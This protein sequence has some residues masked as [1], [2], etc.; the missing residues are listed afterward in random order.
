M[1]A[2]ETVGKIG[3]GCGLPPFKRWLVF[4]LVGGMGIV[5]QLAV[6]VALTG[7]MDWNYLVATAAAV[8]A[9]VLHNFFWHEHWTWAE[10]AGGGRVSLLG[11]LVR[12]HLTNGA[13]SLLGNILLM[14]FF[15][16]RLSMNYTAANL[17]AITVCSILNF[18]AGDRVVFPARP[19]RPADQN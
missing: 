10:R 14:Q 1:Q 4:N 2:R 16:G 13:F 11:R 7:L 5:V 9:A 18:F 12:F 8:E 15:V 19:P 3:N 17:S 6:L